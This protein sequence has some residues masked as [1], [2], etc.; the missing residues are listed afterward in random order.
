VSFAIAQNALGVLQLARETVES[1]R[2]PVRGSVTGP[3]H[4]EDAILLLH[5]FAG[6]PRMLAPLRNYLQYEL[7]RPTLGLA[8]GI[9][10]GDIRDAAIRVHEAM[11]QHGVH[12]CDV[13][14]YSLGGLVAAYLLKCLD[15]G[16]SIRRVVT[17]GTPHCGA[18]FLAR[19]PWLL[20]RW[21]R[22]AHQVRAGSRFLAQLSRMPTPAGTG[23]LSIAG[24]EDAIVP[25]V[26]AHLGG[27]D[28]RNLVVPGIDH[29]R[30]PTSRRVF[31][32]VK[33]VLAGT[34]ASWPAPRLEAIAPPTSAPTGFRESARL[35]FASAARRAY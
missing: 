23:M 34:D 27:A 19:W 4:G 13:I 24:A 18:A 11:E 17:L 9:G 5:G 26:T 16:R 10:F 20:A 7:E 28:C 1:W 14:G 8:L 35:C 6:S 29:W 15:Q 30:L 2:A 12:R 25:P 31:R 32:C 22:S 33:E 21:F 3:L